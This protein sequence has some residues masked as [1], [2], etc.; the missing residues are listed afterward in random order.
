[1]VESEPDEKVAT[2][3]GEL[4][5]CTVTFHVGSKQFRL[6]VYIVKCV[7]V[8]YRHMY[9]VFLTSS[10]CKLRKFATVFEIVSNTAV[11][12]TRFSLGF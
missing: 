6:K 8:V 1:M 3:F 7:T 2:L 9:C 12:S 4:N 10:I 11:F 5:N